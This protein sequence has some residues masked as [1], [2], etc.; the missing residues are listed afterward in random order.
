MDVLEAVKRTCVTEQLLHRGERVVVAVSGGPDSTALLHVL[1]RLAAEWDLE[2]VAAHVDHRFRGEQSAQ[3]GEQV[4]RL[5][6]RLG[7]PCE[8]ASIDLPQHI[9][10]T[11][12]NA[13]AAA[14]KKRYAFLREVAERT[15]ADAIALGHHADDQAET[16]LMRLVQ[17]TGPTG[18]AGMP[19]CRKEGQ[20]RLIRPLLKL[21]KSSLIEYCREHELEFAVDPSN[22]KPV[23]FRNRIRMEM[24]PLLKEMN[25]QMVTALSRL[26][27]V[28]TVENQYLDQ[29]TEEAYTSIVRREGDKFSFT[30][31]SFLSLH[32]ALQRRLITLILR[33]LSLAEL[34]YDHTKIEAIQEAIEKETPPSLRLDIGQGIQL[35]REYEQISILKK[36]RP[37]TEIEYMYRLQMPPCELYVPEAGVTFRLH[38]QSAHPPS[39]PEPIPQ[40]DAHALR[41]DFDRVQFPLYIRNRRPGD[42]MRIAGLN[43][44]KKVKDIFID[45][46]LPP[47]L[48]RRI[49]L[50]TDSRGEILWIPG[51]RRSEHALVTETT[52]RILHIICVPFI[53]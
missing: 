32:L 7:I 30:R 14:R 26:S 33:Y 19:I 47:S 22:L 29:Q 2:L 45:A 8:S 25:P 37:D 3:E 41:L 15:G 16:M 11:N 21:P 12:E 18:L 9:A 23:Y 40:T 6:N 4:R 49:P 13:Q 42:R 44:S 5:A 38:V 31:N 20:F 48:R 24:I 10:L 51:V 36:S 17:G 28:L 34:P 35:I 53:T 1:Y 52:Q 39:G 46:K 43:G 50:L 27:D